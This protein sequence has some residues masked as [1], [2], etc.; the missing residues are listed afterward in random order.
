MRTERTAT[1]APDTTIVVGYTPTP[2]GEA[3]VRA[4]VDEARLRGASLYVVN[5]SRGDA[6]VDRNLASRQHL[7]ELQRLL[8]ESGIQH[9]VVQE[10]GRGEPSEELLRAVEET[11]AAL[12]VIGLRHRTPVG[13]LLLGSTAQQ[14]LLDAPCPV[15]GVKP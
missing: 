4:A 6:Y 5:V 12:V 8:A 15:L 10:V 14:I 3:A 2:A 9:R 1:P 7:N 13:K 11:N